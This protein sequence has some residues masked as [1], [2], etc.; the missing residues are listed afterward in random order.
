MLIGIAIASDTEAESIKFVLK[1]NSDNNIIW[2]INDGKEIIQKCLLQKPDLILLDLLLL[3]SEGVEVIQKIMNISPCPILLI[4]KNVQQNSSKIFE[5]LGAGALDV[6]TTPVFTL[7][8]KI[9]GSEEF[10]KKI[11]TIEKLIV[12]DDKSPKINK[13]IFETSSFYLP[14]LIVIGSSTG[15]PKALADILKN[16]PSK[17]DSAVII[18]QH[19]DVQFAESLID[20]LN[21]QVEMNVLLAKEGE[22]PLPNNIYVA[23]TNDHLILGPDYKFHYTIEPKDFPYRPSVDTF[24][25]SLSQNVKQKNIAVLLTGMGKD[26]AVGL[27]ELR[28]KGW[29]TIA[30]DK[31]TSVVFGMPK[32]AIELNAA[33]EILPIEKIASS[34]I[35]HLYKKDLHHDKFKY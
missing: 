1:S 28:R 35:N 16:F 25:L 2:I 33:V 8:G 15:G 23:V 18:V 31:S 12:K 20:W 9:I 14:K 26:G 17:I 30:Q 7:D 27:L 3:N 10:Q 24:F 22:H 21:D 19:I 5:A 32:A 11:S 13:K 29:H 34:I 4:T 6:A